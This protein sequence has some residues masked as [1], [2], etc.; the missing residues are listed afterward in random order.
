MTRPGVPSAKDRLYV[1]LIGGTPEEVNMG[2]ITRRTAWRKV[3]A[4]LPEIEAEAQS[5]QLARIDALRQVIDEAVT[6]LNQVW[7]E[8]KDGWGGKND[9][10]VRTI[11][12]LQRA[13]TK[14]DILN[15]KDWTSTR[16]STKP[17][18]ER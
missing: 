7:F 1:S 8:T 3:E 17:E 18:P 13:R 10:L 12:W 2:S 5:D 4:L 6:S 14:D 9:R 11:S 15:G 16:P